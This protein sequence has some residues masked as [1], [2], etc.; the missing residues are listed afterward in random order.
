MGDYT[1]GEI[2]IAADAIREEAN[3]FY[4]LSERMGK[5]RETTAALPLPQSSFLIADPATGEVTAADLKDTYDRM[6]GKL[7]MLFQQATEQFELFG[8]ALRRAADSYERTDAESAV[9][10]KEIWTGE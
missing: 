9:N 1:T 7:T 6:H 8:D 3:K 10:L 5:V 4:K 2:R